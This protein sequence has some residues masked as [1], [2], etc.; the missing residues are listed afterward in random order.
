[1]DIGQMFTY[2][3][4]GFF[5]QKLIFEKRRIK[6]IVTFC[7]RFLSFC[8]HQIVGNVQV[9]LVQLHKMCLYQQ[10]CGLNSSTSY[11]FL[12]ELCYLP[13]FLSI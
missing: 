6:K 11:N 5:I 12:T 2:F 4:Y 7:G 9:N 10:V 3:L 8:F 13:T 1:M